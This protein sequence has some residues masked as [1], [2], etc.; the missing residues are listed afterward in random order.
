MPTRHGR[1]E[2]HAAV[3][4]VCSRHHTEFS[5]VRRRAAA[6]AIA[7]AAKSKGRA[8]RPS[9][10]KAVR[11]P[12]FSSPPPATNWHRQTA[13]R[14]L[15]RQQSPFRSLATS[16]RRASG[17][18]R[19][20]ASVRRWRLLWSRALLTPRR[21]GRGGTSRPGLASCPSRTR[22]G[23]KTSLAASVNKAIAICAACLRPARLPS[24]AM[25]KSM[26]PSVDRLVGT[27]AHQG[28]C[29]RT[30]QQARQDGMGD[31]GRNERYKEPAA[32]M[33]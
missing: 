27:S 11:P 1:A 23:A 8:Q 7:V 17:S 19:S 4:Y 29:H 33:A 9:L 26:A 2:H 28:R 3:S 16:A 10:R 32:L 21:S 25:R 5:P 20:P 30:R 24:S 14:S 13:S 18:T 12:P 22:V 6:R 15:Q 31:D